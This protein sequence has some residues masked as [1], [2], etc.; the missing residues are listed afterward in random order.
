MA[1]I[2]SD[3]NIT[4]GVSHTTADLFFVTS[5]AIIN[6]TTGLTIFLPAGAPHWAT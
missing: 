4:Y 5:T 2:I 1:V 6:N 3:S